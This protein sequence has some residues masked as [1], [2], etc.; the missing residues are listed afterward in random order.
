MASD[1]KA[2]AIR[3]LEAAD[4]QAFS[5]LG[6]ERP[7]TERCVLDVHMVFNGCVN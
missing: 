1:H 7:R 6:G 3:P 4:F 2:E 5:V